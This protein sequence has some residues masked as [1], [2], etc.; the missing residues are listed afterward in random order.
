MRRISLTIVAAAACLAS[1]SLMAAE[2]P[3]SQLP[4]D[5]PVVQRWSQVLDAAWPLQASN[6]ALCPDA[7]KHLVGLQSGEVLSGHGINVVS[8]PT[9]SPAAVAGLL[10]GDVITEINGTEFDARKP[11]KNLERYQEFREDVDDSPW[12]VSLLRAG[13]PLSL[14][15]NPVLACDFQVLYVPTPLPVTRQGNI[16]ITGS[17]MDSATSTR[18][19]VQIYL[20]QQFGL[21]AGSQTGKRAG[22]KG[23]LNRASAI[24][25]FA[26]GVN[27]GGGEGMLAGMIHGKK[28]SL[29]G[30]RIALYMLARAG[31]DME[32]VSSFYPQLMQASATGVVG[33][34][35]GLSSAPVEERQAAVSSTVEEIRVKQQS[36][37]ALSIDEAS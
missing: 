28:Q 31:V 29:E 12:Q 20:A 10:A 27:L 7:A 4:L 21:I 8:V 26:T 9:D 16:V 36:G 17:E 14:T 11:A 5:H 25:S 2:T 34:L 22:T 35:Q 3:A 24:G 18:A 30:D 23:W 13:A 32:K 6:A 19:E 1:S 33:K 37:A 15:I